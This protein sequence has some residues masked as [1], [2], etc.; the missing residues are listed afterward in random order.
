MSQLKN[1]ASSRTSK[2]FFKVT[3][4]VPKASKDKKDLS[5]CDLCTCVIESPNDLLKCQGPCQQ[6][7]H[8]YCAGVTRT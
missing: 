4:K 1:K 6:T 3:S 5:T 8:R 7:M 2:L